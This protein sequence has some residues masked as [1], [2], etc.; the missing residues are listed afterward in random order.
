[1]LSLR[2]SEIESF[3]FIDPPDTKNIRNGI[4]V[5]KELGA[6]GLKNSPEPEATDGFRR[7]GNGQGP[8][9][10]TELGWKMAALPMDPR[11]SRI[12]IEAEKEGC[13]REVTIIAA[14]LSTQDPREF[15][16]D[17]VDAAREAH[18][19]FKDASSDFMTYV[20]I[21]DHVH[22]SGEDFNSQK[23][24]RKF[25]R[26]HFLSYKRLREWFDIREQISS[27]MKDSGFRMPRSEETH[28]KEAFCGSSGSSTL[29]ESLYAGIHRSILSGYLSNIAIRKENN[30]YV[31]A[32]GRQIMLFPGSGLFNKGA[33]WIV[34]AE[35][36]ETS[37]IFARNVAAISPQWLEPLGGTLC[38]YTYSNPHWERKRGEVVASEQVSLFGL[39]I[40]S[41]RPASYGRVFPEEA[42]RIF[43]RSAL[44]EADM[45]K[46][47]RFLARN[48]TL[49]ERI[50]QMEDKL[51]R[52]DLLVS[53]EVLFAFYHERLAGIYDMRTLMKRVRDKGGDEF[54][55]LSEE[56]LLQ[57]A[58]DRSELEKFPDQ[59]SF[60]KLSFPLG[61][62]FRPGEQD[63][64][65]TMAVPFGLASAVPV[66]STEWLVPGLLREKITLLIKSLPKEY[67]KKLLPIA[68]AIDTVLDEMPR[69]RDPL[70]FALSSFLFEKYGVDIPT[71]A[72]NAENLPPHLRMRVSI[73]DTKGAEM[74]AS[75][76]IRALQQEVSGEAETRALLR[77]KKNWERSELLSWDFGDLP[78]SIVLEGA[79]GVEGLAYPALFSDPDSEGKERV[80]LRIFSSINAS[81]AEHR[82]GVAALFS[83][84]FQKE[85]NYLKKQ[86]ALTKEMK[87][88]AAYFGGE[89]NVERKI[90][91]RVVRKLFYLPITTEQEFHRHAESLSGKIPEKAL[92]ALEEIA[93]LLKAYAAARQTLSNMEG[94][95]RANRMALHFLAGIREELDRLV[96]DDFI[97]R[98]ENSRL[99]EI[100]R[101]LKA[102]EIRAQQGLVHL[103]KDR[104]KAA[105][106]RIYE[107]RLRALTK[108]LSADASEDKARAVEAFR[109][110]V[111]EYKVAIFA[112]RIRTPFPVSPKRLDEKLRQIEHLA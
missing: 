65:V 83:I 30:F 108:S 17:Q 15:P 102:L 31:M 5:L 75:R 66:G 19:V 52:C 91:E 33:D 54:L 68:S 95:N 43:V 46:P 62:R 76:D 39:I 103:E 87:S 22:G 97:A 16:L 99:T 71:K 1:M 85:M 42:S 101:Y 11:I 58:P 72:W 80:H 8:W 50:S 2:I 60:G 26:S 48:R 4:E 112:Q 70:I 45:E 37:R 100:P 47:P 40:V 82:K 44:V 56:D 29:Q 88:W 79:G 81:L 104:E 69:T 92:E 23:K 105:Q 18:G 73:V 64:G 20:N 107:D 25:C 9:T 98:Y 10:L 84:H 49:I 35:V 111:E 90:R 13:L 93:P 53:D 109:W 3:P 41:A 14:A 106:V 34:A 28:G 110:M 57:H 77:A 86:I 67:R 55:I 94:K 7:P 96:P 27:I 36:V 32:G 63:D 6:I 38:R 74:R 12:V 59:L 21:W 89:K 78:E 24:I 51:R 61:Y